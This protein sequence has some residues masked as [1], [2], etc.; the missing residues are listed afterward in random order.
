MD[1]KRTN[2]YSEVS[3]LII[4][5][6]GMSAMLNVDLRTAQDVLYVPGDAI[7]TVGE[8]TLATMVSSTGQVVDTPVRVGATFGSNVE[9]LSGL[10]EGDVVTVFSATVAS[11]K[12]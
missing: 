8:Q 2:A 5:K 6:L 11:A 10:Q 3:T 7:R 4:L 12:R 1:A 9:V